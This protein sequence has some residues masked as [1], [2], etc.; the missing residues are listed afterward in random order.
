MTEY[1]PPPPGGYPPPPPPQGGY[2]PPGPQG[3]PP[4]NN[5]VWA[6]LSTILCCIPVGAFA[7]YKS[8]QVSGLWAQGRFAEAQQAADDAKKFAI[9]GAIAGVAFSVIWII[10]LVATGAFSASV[11]SY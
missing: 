11:T 5:L 1:P 7:I 2:G 9:W 3:A 4:D 8:T 10:F 6:I